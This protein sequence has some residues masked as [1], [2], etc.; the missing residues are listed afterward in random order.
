VRATAFRELGRR[1]LSRDAA[2]HL[3]RAILD[4]T[5]SPGERLPSERELAARL[6]VSRPTL[7]E[8][9]S[10]L[11][12]TGLLE[13]RHGAGT[14]VANA[15]DESG[16]GATI[17]ID[18]QSDPLTALFEYRLLFE[19][20]AASRAAARITRAELAE[21][22]RMLE[23][24]AAAVPSADEFVRIDAEF[25][26]AI[27]VAARSAATLAMLDSLADLAFR[28]RT[29]SGRDPALRERTVDEHRVILDALRRHD[30]FEAEAA[31][32]AHL[33]HIRGSM[34]GQTT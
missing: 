1:S 24:L 33:M 34:I 13:S 20:A 15:L 16:I 11:V 2:E 31:M 12:I 19:P 29:I 6:G 26:R 17:A 22:S 14:F 10:A 21:L 23:E 18:I 32:T 28:G 5:L 3:K 27:H 8:A 9:V 7:R 4:G 25:H 30:P